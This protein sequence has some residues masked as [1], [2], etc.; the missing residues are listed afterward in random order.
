MIYT[1]L[2]LNLYTDNLEGLIDFYVNKLQFNSSS[3]HNGL[4]A[5]LKNGHASITLLKRN[6]DQT[7][8]AGQTFFALHVD[9]LDSTKEQIGRSGV[10]I[11]EYQDSDFFMIKDC[12]GNKITISQSRD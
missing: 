5:R 9:D 7:P 1:N 8:S 2:V 11:V 10:E 12:D 6:G 3:L 4:V